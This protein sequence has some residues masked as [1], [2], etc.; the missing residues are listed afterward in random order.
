MKACTKQ[1]HVDMWDTKVRKALNLA[2]PS[3]QDLLPWTA[4]TL[5]IKLS[6]QKKQNPT[7]KNVAKNW[8]PF[9]IP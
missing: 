7:K 9:A 2:H 4:H 8:S 1:R 3:K 6:F 5:F